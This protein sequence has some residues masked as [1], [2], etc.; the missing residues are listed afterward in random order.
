MGMVANWP[1]M[2]GGASLA[3]AASAAL[4]MRCSNASTSKMMGWPFG[5]SPANPGDA[6]SLAIPDVTGIC[7]MVG[8]ARLAH[9]PV[10]SPPAS[11]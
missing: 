11:R 10:A 4:L 5:L 3:L 9:L 6:Y 8:N 2:A 7:Q 1:S